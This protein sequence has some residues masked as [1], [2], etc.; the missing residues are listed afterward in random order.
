[1]AASGWRATGVSRFWAA[2]GLDI[3]NEPQGP[4]QKCHPW[5]FGFGVSGSRCVVVTRE[6]WSPIREKVG[7]RVQQSAHKRELRVS[8]QAL[9]TGSRQ[10]L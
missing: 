3:L 1:M 6:R 4:R 9:K 7:M 8:S 2:C 10:H 5:M